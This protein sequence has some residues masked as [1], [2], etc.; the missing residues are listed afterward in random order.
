[1]TER[2]RPTKIHKF[3]EV[4]EKVLFTDSLMLLTDEE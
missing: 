3:I 4:A 2:G 1:M